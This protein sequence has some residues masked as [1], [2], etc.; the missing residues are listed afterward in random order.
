MR[1]IERTTHCWVVLR[2]EVRPFQDATVLRTW[3]VFRYE[4]DARVY[5]FGLDGIVARVDV[6]FESLLDPIV[7]A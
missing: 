5:A 4:A 3:T 7:R 6:D 2:A 1:H